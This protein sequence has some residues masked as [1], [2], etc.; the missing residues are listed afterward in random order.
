[1]TDNLKIA[2]QFD[3]GKGGILVARIPKKN[4]LYCYGASPTMAQYRPGENEYVWGGG[5][6]TE[7][8]FY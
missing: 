1:M 6:I 8:E 2:K 4:I 5:E 7:Y 3:G